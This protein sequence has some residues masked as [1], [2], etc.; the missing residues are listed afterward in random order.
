MS[1][2]SNFLE[3]LYKTAPVGLCY[4]DREFRFAYV[5]DWLLDILQRPA[6]EI[7]G[8]KFA[9]LVPEIAHQIEPQLHE[10]VETRKPLLNLETTGSVPP[11]IHKIRTFLANHYPIFSK[12]GEFEGISVVVQDV[13]ER[14]KA[15]EAY[16][17][18]EEKFRALAE[19][20]PNMI[21]INANGRVVYANQRCEEIIGYSHEEFYAP[22]FNFKTLISSRHLEKVEANF[23]KHMEGREVEPYE[24]DIVTKD[25]KI[26]PTIITTKLINYEKGKAILGIVT[27]ITEYKAAQGAVIKAKEELEGKVEERTSDLVKTNQELEEALK[28]RKEAEEALRASEEK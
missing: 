8:K 27:D 16:K 25:G 2:S 22:D 18:S 26:L 20:S 7:L 19:Q 6:S 23:R 24:Y 10:M 3:N 28:Q 21:F 14:K 11:D 5:N 9:D 12:T 1:S 15:E 13:T 4:F 17:K